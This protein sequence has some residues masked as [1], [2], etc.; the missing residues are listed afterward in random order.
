[1]RNIRWLLILFIILSPLPALA[2]KLQNPLGI[3]GDPRE[4]FARLTGGLASF[5]GILAL[6]FFILGGYR[7]LTAAGNSE[8]FA[9]GKT[10]ILYSVVGFVITL[11][12]YYILFQVISILTDKDTLTGFTTKPGLFD[13]LNLDISCSNMR[14]AFYSGRI[15]RSLLS[16]LGGLTL[17][18]FVY[19]GL[20]WM[21]AAGNEEKIIKAKKTIMYAI[22]GLAAVL[23]S[24]VIL[25]FA[26]LPFYQ[27]LGGGSASSTCSTS[28][29][30][31]QGN[32]ACFDLDGYCIDT[33]Q[34]ACTKIGGSFYAGNTCNEVGC[35]VQNKACITGQ[36]PASQF[37]TSADDCVPYIFTSCYAGLP[38][39]GLCMGSED[40]SYDGQCYSQ[41]TFQAGQKCH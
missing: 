6:V 14:V 22:L 39:S 3:A 2:L 25:K 29:A 40:Y 30:D 17:L 35:C 21:L 26:Y 13:P 8:H 37:V 5:T 9:K 15:L 32:H 36:T 12:S 31:S 19:G 4:I 11:S 20:Q 28:T 7:I 23:G 34:L 1:M 41:V 38:P 18:M 27:L 33:S 24:Y 16:G 10:M